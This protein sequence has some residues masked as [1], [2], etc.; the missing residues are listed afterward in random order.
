VAK[1]FSMGQLSDALNELLPPG[2]GHG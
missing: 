1:P 2:S